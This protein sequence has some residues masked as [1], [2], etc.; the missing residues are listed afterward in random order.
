MTL[1]VQ[2][3][4]LSPR[5]AETA[6]R[7]LNGLAAAMEPTPERSAIELAAKHFRLALDAAAAARK[8]LGARA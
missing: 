8:V 2:S 1:T 3:N 5:A 4:R 7:G 6:L